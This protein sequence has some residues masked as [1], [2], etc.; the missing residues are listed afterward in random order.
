MHHNM[1]SEKYNLLDGKIRI[2]SGLSD[3]QIRLAYQ[4]CLFTVFP[5]Y[6]EGWGLPISECLSF[7]KFCVASNATS[8]PE[9]GGKFCDYFDPADEAA[10]FD[11]IEMTIFQSGV[12]ASRE[13]E[14]QKKYR[15]TNCAA[16]VQNSAAVGLNSAAVGRSGPAVGH[17]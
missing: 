3:A 1:N 17:A 6:C 16:V 9:A 5:S 8:I 2:A 15:A 7:G 13:A 10:A 14:I 4:N 12:L 11:L